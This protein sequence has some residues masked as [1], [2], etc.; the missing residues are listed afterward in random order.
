MVTGKLRHLQTRNTLKNDCRSLEVGLTFAGTCPTSVKSKAMLS[1]KLEIGT[2]AA[3]L[4]MSN[5]LDSNDEC[6]AK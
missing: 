4:H 2:P 6:V 5:S 1:C 3:C